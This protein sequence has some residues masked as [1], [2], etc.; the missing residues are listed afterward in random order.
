VSAGTRSPLPVGFGNM[1]D[2][3]PIASERAL[4]DLLVRPSGRPS[5]APLVRYRS[6]QYQA[7]SWD[8]PRRVI[9]KVEHHLGEREPVHN[10]GCLL[11]SRTLWVRFELD[12]LTRNPQGTETRLSVPET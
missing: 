4:E 11:S 7:A 5:R 1:A 9:A 12:S 8:R 3:I 6:F 2:L 10:I